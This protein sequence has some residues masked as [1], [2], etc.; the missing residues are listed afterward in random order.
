[1]DTDTLAKIIQQPTCT[2]KGQIAVLAFVDY[3]CLPRF[4]LARQPTGPPWQFIL[5]Y[6]KTKMGAI[7]PIFLNS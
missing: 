5:D 7:A 1:M 6:L 2:Y 3:R 4:V